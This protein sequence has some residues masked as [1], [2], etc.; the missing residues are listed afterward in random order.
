MSNSPHMH[1]TSAQLVA[2]LLDVG[3][4]DGDNRFIGARKP[5]GKGRVYGGQV[6]GQA[7]MAAAKTV[8]EDRL[9]HSLHCYFMRPASE[10]HEIAYAVEADMDGGAFSNRRVVAWQGG[11]PIFNM[12]ASFQRAEEG[13]H[14]Q[15]AM[16]AVVPPEDLPSLRLFDRPESPSPLELRPVG[17]WRRPPAVPGTTNAMCWFR[18]DCGEGVSAGDIPG[19][20]RIQRAILG[21]MSDA[22]LLATVFL[23]H[24]RIIG[25]N[26]LQTASLDHAVWIHDD[27]DC[28]EWLLYATDSPW[29]G[30]A[31]GFARG[32][33]FTRDGRLVASTVQEGLIRPVSAPP[34]G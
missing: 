8:S 11:K 32:Q 12:L 31:R 16:P 14:H 20:Q 33:F 7:M 2:R 10:D 22:I 21:M 28:C 34:S 4:G 29:S 15:F 18:L 17:D 24:G 9:C 30:N 6:V 23:P 27:V 13:L 1:L 26:T 25:D 3:P 5:G 19:G